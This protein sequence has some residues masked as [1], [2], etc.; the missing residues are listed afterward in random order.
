VDR[1]ATWDIQVTNAGEVPLSN[2]VVRDLLPP[3][4]TFQDASAGGRLEGEHVVW[5]LGTLQPREQKALQVTTRAAK[6]T[7]RAL[8]RV[9]AT[10]E[11]GQT[12][13]EEA[14][15]EIRGLPAFKLEVTDRDDPVEVGARTA[16]R[17]E[18]TNQGSL[19]GNQVE[20]VAV[21]PAQMRL[22]GATGPVRHRIE[23]QRVVFEPLDA[24]A[25]KQTASY[26]VEVQATQGGDARFRLE[27][28]SS[29]LTDPVT[30]EESTTIVAPGNEGRPAP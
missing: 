12:A 11:P 27:L 25:P 16:Y 6:L 7:P 9:Q 17:I 8:N 24:L 26:A 21:V 4:L 2:V 15:I 28:R 19:P 14:A 13:Q 18:V 10:A 22:L 3:E 1:P 5:S 29:T 20:I 30:Q 23:G